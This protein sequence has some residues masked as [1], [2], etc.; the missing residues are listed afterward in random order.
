MSA[1]AVIINVVK[2]PN[3]KILLVHSNVHVLKD[4]PM[5]ILVHV[6]ISMNVP[7]VHMSVTRVKSA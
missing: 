1:R 2:I 3:A 4:F 7:T 5:K 6:T